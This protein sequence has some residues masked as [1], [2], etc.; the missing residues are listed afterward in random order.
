LCAAL[1]GDDQP[2]STASISLQDQA[3]IDVSEVQGLR[4]AALEI[5]FDHQRLRVDPRDVRAGSAWGGKGL[6]IANVDND[7]G[8]INIFVFS[9]RESELSHGSLV[10]IDFQRSDGDSDADDALPLI[11]VNR[12]RLNDND[13]SFAD[14][15]P[16][17][18]NSMHNAPEGLPK[19]SLQFKIAPEGEGEID[20][21]TQWQDENFVNMRSNI[22]IGHTDT[23]H[24][25]AAS[26]PQK[27]L[28]NQKQLILLPTVFEDQVS[29]QNLFA[30]NEDLEA[31]SG[32]VCQPL[33]VA[34]SQV[35]LA[36]A[37]WFGNTGELKGPILPEVL[38]DAVAHAA[39]AAN[40]D[41]A[42]ERGMEVEPLR[43]K[44]IHGSEQRVNG[45]PDFPVVPLDA[46]H[47]GFGSEF[48]P[49]WE[50][51]G[52]DAPEKLSDQLLKA[53]FQAE[54]ARLTIGQ[55]SSAGMYR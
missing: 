49:K 42:M 29:D 10:E 52:G 19:L 36:I 38:Q 35:D 37:Q 44:T 43:S 8:K 50:S 45:F 24:R 47:Q 15:E 39:P 16:T 46:I 9:A 11:D 51:A 12:L 55:M 14:S 25:D 6:S 2:T 27:D 28:H 30:S 20:L 21:A 40:S 32:E 41:E 5:S 13:I 4:G 53:A 48:D 22:D 54:F 26:Q 34:S 31:H 18:S 1:E 23:D 17:T 3:S 33:K 7:E